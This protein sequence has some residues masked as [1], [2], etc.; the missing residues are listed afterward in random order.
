MCVG[1]VCT[2][3]NASQSLRL[4][5]LRQK[6]CITFTCT[7]HN[8]SMVSK[9]RRI[10]GTVLKATKGSPQSLVIAHTK[11]ETEVLHYKKEG[12]YIHRSVQ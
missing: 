1:G 8:A 6:R 2:T 11:E 5:T 7:I 9:Y 10:S 12:V 3:G 4:C